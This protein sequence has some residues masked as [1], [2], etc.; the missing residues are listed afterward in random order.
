MQNSFNSIITKLAAYI[1]K[2]YLIELGRGL[3]LFLAFNG[4]LFIGMAM[5][6]SVVHLSAQTRTA[7]M[8]FYALVLVMGL[9]YW[10]VWPMAKRMG[11]MKRM[12][13]MQAA[14]RIHANNAVLGEKLINALELN[15][16]SQDDGSFV[17]AALDQ[18]QKDI[19]VFDLV[20]FVR[21]KEIRRA[22]YY[23][24]GVL[25][26]FV[27]LLVSGSA[28]NLKEGTKRMM[29]F[30][31]EFLPKD[32]VAFEFDYEKEI[33]QGQDY[34]LVVHTTSA[35][36]VEDVQ[37]FV[38]GVSYVGQS[39][40]LNKFE[41]VVRNVQRDLTFYAQS[42]QYRSEVNDVVMRYSP[43]INSIRT[44]IT[45]PGYTDL[46]KIVTDGE[47]AWRI[48]ENSDIQLVIEA[49]HVQGVSLGWNDSLV[50]LEQGSS[51]SY[52]YAEEAL[53]ESREWSVLSADRKIGSMEVEIIEDQLPRLEVELIK[54][55]ANVNS[56]VLMGKVSDDYGFHSLTAVINNSVMHRL[57]LNSKREQGF[58]FP[59]EGYDKNI[60]VYMEV[61]DNDKPNG[62]KR[63]RSQELEVIF[64]SEEE[65]NQ[66]LRN[67]N[68]MNRES[69]S[70]Q[71]K[72]LNKLDRSEEKSSWERKEE[73]EREKEKWESI[74]E[75]HKRMKE[76]WEKQ[77]DDEQKDEISERLDETEKDLQELLEKI[78]ELQK[79]ID[80][81][82]EEM[83]AVELN[84][85]TVQME[86][87]RSLE[88]MRE[89]YLKQLLD[90]SI[91]TLKDLESEQDSLAN[92][93]EDSVEEQ[94][95]LKEKAE[96]LSDML[97]EMNEL[98]EEME[99]DAGSEKE[100]VKEAQE[101]MEKASEKMN[102]GKKNDANENQ[103]KAK[104][105]LSQARQKLEEE[106]SMMMGGSAE[107][108]EDLSVL[109]NN[110]VR[111]SVKEEVLIKELRVIDTDHPAY[112]GKMIEQAKLRDESKVIR[113]SLHALMKRVP[114][115]ENVVLKEMETM[116][117]YFEQ[118][119]ENLKNNK[120]DVAVGEMQYVMLASNNLA[121]MLD[122]S[123][124]NMQSN[125]SQQSSGD[126]SCDK[127]G[128][129]KPGMKGLKKMQVELQK[130]MQNAQKEKGKAE[131]KG[132]PG[133]KRELAKMMAR[134]ELIRMQLEKMEG[135]E[136]GGSDGNA[137]LLKELE[138]LMKENERDLAE[139]NLDEEFMNRQKEIE[140][141]MLESEK[142]E[143]ER[144]MDDKREAV[145]NRDEYE[146]KR[147]KAL[148]EYLKE[149]Y[150]SLEGL[151]LDNVDLS[152]F[153][154]EKLN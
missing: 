131:G 88:L 146:M 26:V 19:R 37:V 147:R 93:N 73:L 80:P 40:G 135:E 70:E 12:S 129:S 63:V 66:G 55:S 123:L 60:K 118:S 36:A 30:Q 103:E 58:Y 77:Q 91:E 9:G 96:D 18:I 49:Q 8:G 38:N 115:I 148:E 78:E 109:L 34:Q 29:A 27:I 64:L 89:E 92:S 23:G 154:N 79:K 142:A 150:K 107:S 47:N 52:M 112:Q 6:M 53:K 25:A 31:T 71:M 13:F 124:E 3:V 14:Y 108:M 94:E 127:P 62:F 139:G 65:I 4:F 87:E 122:Q 119:N 2:V 35:Y 7:W 143:K 114:E 21:W 104:E 90:E 134:Q 132:S 117:R 54:D 15:Q 111:L 1:N 67:Q 95:Q 39:I 152:D 133:G 153:Y 59:L 125:M 75:E 11:W 84:M 126:Q 97:E 20:E 69:L 105:K 41:V 110:V 144:E 82:E 128:Q 121:L 43:L 22:A 100:D 24:F 151:Q 76:N 81:N 33:E 85:E 136:N 116:T 120:K 56:Y 51:E 44:V 140:N 141:K 137:K 45:P 32:H 48:P 17:S 10:I 61:R 101:E 72:D 28:D 102:Q 86:L 46:D 74:Q 99:K 57:P 50:V 130:D 5:L 113:D 106:Q 68:A 149:K 138:E 42:G 16:V 98:K 145:T 83:R